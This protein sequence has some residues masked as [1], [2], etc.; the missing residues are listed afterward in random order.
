[1]CACVIAALLLDV[2]LDTPVRLAS[3][4]VK[5]C[6]FSTNSTY[7]PLLVKQWYVLANGILTNNACNGT[8]RSP[9]TRSR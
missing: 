8:V 9:S 1:M 7:Q 3:A 6:K 2:V 5:T 4:S